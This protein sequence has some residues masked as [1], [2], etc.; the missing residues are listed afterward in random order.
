M[1]RR[2]MSTVRWRLVSL[3]AVA[4]LAGW[5]PAGLG[6]EPQAGL[7]GDCIVLGQVSSL[8]SLVSQAGEFMAEVQPGTN[9]QMVGMLLG[10]ALGNPMFAGVDRAKPVWIVV[11][12]PMKYGTKPVLVVPLSAQGQFDGAL[13]TAMTKGQEAEGVTPFTQ[14]NGRAIFL[15]YGNGAAVVAQSKLS[16]QTVLGLWTAGEVKPEAIGLPS[17]EAPIVFTVDMVKVWGTYEPMVM[18]MMQTF[19]QAAA[20][21]MQQQGQAQADAEKITAILEAEIGWLVSIA[22]QLETVSVGLSLGKNGLTI[23]EYLTFKA[24][25]PLAQFV[26]V[27]K[28]QELKLLSYLPQ[29]VMIAG[30]ARIDGADQVME[31]YMGFLELFMSDTNKE[32]LDLFKEQVQAWSQCVGEEVAMAMVPPQEG[33]GMELVYLLSLKDPQLAAK[34]YLDMMKNMAAMKGFA[35]GMGQNAEITFAENVDKYK[36]YTIHRQTTKFSKDDMMPQQAEAMTRMFGEEMIV[37]TCMVKD[38]WVIGFGPNARQRLTDTVDAVLAGGA[39]FP[40]ATGVVEVFGK[41]PTDQSAVAYVSLGDLLDWALKFVPVPVPISYDSSGGIGVMARASG[42]QVVIK[43]IV[44]M[45]EIVAM[46]NAFMDMRRG[47]QP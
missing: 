14:P 16:C 47:P 25:T 1:V 30:G 3:F 12:D 29:D 32:A 23:Q 44:P 40:S 19:K 2:K 45:G 34:T 9:A 18:G 8:N 4:V 27:Q 24:G 10:Q 41:L 21:S 36:G 46:R 26:G 42:R 22:Q 20:M 13:A 33:T 39:G 15:G 28:P 43:T 11:L 31:W 37:E 7:P 5:T 6:E 35:S 17:G 38:K